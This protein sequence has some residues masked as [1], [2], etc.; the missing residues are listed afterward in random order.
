MK[1]CRGTMLIGERAAFDPAKP[2]LRLAVKKGKGGK[3]LKFN[4]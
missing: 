4:G 1:V 2:D 3:R